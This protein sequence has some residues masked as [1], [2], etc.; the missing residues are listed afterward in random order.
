VAP[1]VREVLDSRA[2]AAEACLAWGNAL[3]YLLV[4]FKGLA[5]PGIRHAYPTE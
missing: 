3:D 1:K 2:E 4:M 5:P